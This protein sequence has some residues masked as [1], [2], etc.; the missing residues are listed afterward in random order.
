MK[1]IRQHDQ[2]DCGAA[3]LAMVAAYHKLYLPLPRCREL[4]KTDR[5][6]TNLY[7]LVDGGRQLGFDSEALSG[8]AEEMMEG[9]SA[10][11]IPFPFIAHTVTED[12]MLHYVVVFDFRNGI[13]VI[14]DPGKGK[15]KLPAEVFF[16]LWSGYIVT[17]RKTEAFHE[18]NEKRGE[19]LMFFRL[20]K[21]QW[22]RLAGIL[23]ITIVATAIGIIGTLV[24]QLVIDN[25]AF[26]QGYVVEEVHV[27]EDTGAHEGEVSNDHDHE[28]ASV[29]IHALEEFFDQV[30]GRFNLLFSALLCLYLLQAAIQLL[31]GW[32][33]IQISRTIDLRLTLSYYN[34]I[35]DLPISSISVRQTG[36]YLSRFS[37]TGTI[38]QAI[39]GATI[40]LLMDSLMAIAGG[41]ILYLNNRRLFLIALGMVVF[42]AAL[43]LLYRKPVERSN[44]QAMEEDARLQSYFKESIDGIETVK[45][46]SATVQVKEVSTNKFHRFLNAV[47]KAS[48]ISVSQD[49]LVESVNLIGTILI[50]WAGFAMVLTG[51]ITIGSLIT[52]SA[53][54]YFFTEPIKNLIALQPTI[55][56]AL[57]AADRLNDI[58]ELERE[59]IGDQ[60][61][62]AFPRE[63]TLKLPEHI[64]SWEARHVDF[65]YGN[66]GLTLKD[67]NF[68]VSRG[69]RVAIVGESG[70]GKTTLAKLFL[71]FY[72]PET[73]DLLLNGQRLS[74]YALS[75]LRGSI[76]YVDQNA[77]LFSDTIRNNLKLGNPNVSEQ[78][79]IRA[80]EMSKADD[81]IQGFPMGYDT[82]LDENG[83]NLSGG[84]RQRLSLSRAL[85]QHPQL[86]ILDEATSSL[87]TM[88]E[89]SIRDTIFNLEQDIT[90]IIIAH[91][92]TTIRSC[93]RIYVM[94]EGSIAESGTF[95]ELMAAKGEFFRLWNAM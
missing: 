72:E 49:V 67:V 94:K 20:L 56:T 95:D 69:E 41:V 4:T 17:Y 43:A 90:C 33:I 1:I 30:D 2:R 37:D 26:N 82:P 24:F 53:L 23:A 19:F 45:A 66:R 60:A 12:A 25:F 5:I 80:C 34:H 6:G 32:L 85:I 27:H 83:M 48:I 29:I 62:Q 16:T 70:S 18:G 77:F 63:N 44:R 8:T 74:E 75:E 68:I 81:F 73:G 93:D 38:R 58:L 51:Q 55:Q 13:F 76:A 87:D 3:C 46:A 78:D 52:F 57:V 91:R 22:S 65:R 47:V 79:M 21:G 71:R 89:N 50:L 61:G 36:E 39:S 35:I 40:T 54:L 15:R 31:R 28:G 59:E 84:Q 9:I 14:G 42:Y 10:G 88:T 64:D 11:E 7:G 86:L 92:L